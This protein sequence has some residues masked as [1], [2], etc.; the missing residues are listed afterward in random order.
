MEPERRW[1]DYR[2]CF[3]RTNIHCNG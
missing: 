1:T 3:R 2:Y